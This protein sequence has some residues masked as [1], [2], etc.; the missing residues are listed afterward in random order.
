MASATSCNRPEAGSQRRQG[1]PT[2]VIAGTQD[3]ST[4][5]EEGRALAD[6]IPDARLIELDCAPLSNVEQADSVNKALLSFLLP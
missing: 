5:V 2:L 6:A 4:L 1:G 3:L